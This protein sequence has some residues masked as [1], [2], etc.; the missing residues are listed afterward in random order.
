AAIE[1]LGEFDRITL[2]GHDPGRLCETIA[3]QSQ[4]PMRA[5]SRGALHWRRVITGEGI[6][7]AL[8]LGPRFGS[9]VYVGGVE[10]PGIDIGAQLVRKDRRVRE[11]L[12]SR[13]L[14]RRGTDVWLRRVRRAVDEILGVW[15]PTR[16]YLAVPPTLPVP[17]LPAQVAVVPARVSLEDALL[18]WDAAPDRATATL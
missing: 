3:R 14:E 1:Q 8:T 11:Y 15:N 9:S 4:R 16:L 6:E 10:L 12:A 17:E 2:V 5:M 18:V 13:V 7:L